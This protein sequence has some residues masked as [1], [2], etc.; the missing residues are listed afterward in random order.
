MRK[1]ENRKTKIEK[2]EGR[3]SA[4]PISVFHF[5]IFALGSST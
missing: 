3:H 1:D 2:R 4:K 5:S